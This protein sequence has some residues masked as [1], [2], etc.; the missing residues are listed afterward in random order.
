MVK[1]L[2]SISDSAKWDIVFDGA[3]IRISIPK[4]R[5]F[6]S[7]ATLRK[8]RTKSEPSSNNVRS[9]E[10]EVDV[11]ADVDVEST[12][13]STKVD[14]PEKDLFGDEAK[15][16]PAKKKGKETVK[17]DWEMVKGHWNSLAEEHGFS[18]IQ[19]M[20][21]TRKRHYKA[22]TDQ[23]RKQDEFWAV[24]ERE[25]KQLSEFAV[26]GRWFGFDFITESP[27][28]FAKFAEGQY[29]E[30]DGAGGSIDPEIRKLMGK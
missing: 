22:R 29:R 28:K 25:I 18:K 2:K 21:D 27:N 5:H 4:F 16:P 14:S 15:K 9:R 8:L 7:D 10:V 11:E 20:T 26:T 17:V 6:M 13:S 30:D 1:C 24:V 23:G 19:Q 12:V 3:D